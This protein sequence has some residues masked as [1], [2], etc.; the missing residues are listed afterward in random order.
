MTKQFQITAPRCAVCRYIVLAGLFFAVFAS[1][2][3]RNEPLR[4]EGVFIDALGRRY[5]PAEAPR[6]IVS[7]SPSVTEIL[8]AIGAGDRVVGVTQYCDYPAQAQERTL[9]GG[10]S[11]ITVNVEQIRALAPDLVILS[12]NMHT[13]IVA[14]LDNLGIPSFAV[15]PTTFSQVYDTIALIG[16]LSDAVSGAEEVI[17]QM[18][19]KIAAVRNP[20]PDTLP[21]TVFWVLSE[22][23]LMTVGGETF[24]SQAISLAG[25][26]NIFGDLREQWPMVSPEQVL[27]RRP[28]WILSV[29]C[30][31]SEGFELRSPLWQNFPAVREGR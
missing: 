23:P 20:L 28:D 24:I 31:G 4:E 12:A 5:A 22:E 3:P 30:M 8:F 18:R 21:P 14:L 27:F 2:A 10:F 19:E 15:E 9:V 6:S 13:R 16:E 29:D 7:L 11:G 17:A 1:C 26:E 25:G